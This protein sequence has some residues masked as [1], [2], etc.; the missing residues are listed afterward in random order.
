[1]TV[2]RLVKYLQM[3]VIQTE[4]EAGMDGA[5]GASAR[6]Q[7]PVGDEARV[8]YWV[9]TDPDLYALEQARIFSGPT[10]SYV[11]L[12][13]EV[14]DVGSFKRTAIGERP[15]VVVRGADGTIR[16][17]ENRCA[18][19][20]VK[21][22]QQDFGTTTEFL[23]PYH[24]WRYDL[25]G[26]LTSVPYRRGL[27]GQGGM[28][29]EFRLE[30]HSLKQLKVVERGGAV[31]ASFA[32]APPTF[33]DY[34]GPKML[35]Y[36]D[37]LF[38]GRPLEVLGYSRQRIPGNWKLMLENIKDPYHAGTLHVFFVTFGLFR[39]DQPSRIEM[40]DTGMHAVLV[41]QKGEQVANEV[42]SNL[43]Q[44][45]GDLRLADPRILDPVK[46]F[47]GPET[48]VMQTLWPNV[49]L[50]Q[51]TNSLSTRQIQPRGPGAFDFVW[52]HFTY[53]DDTPEMKQRRLRQA[54]LFGPAGLV[55]VDDGEVIEM[56]Q[57]GLVGY[58]EAAA[59]VEMGGYSVDDTQH[60]LTEA[61]IRKLYRHYRQVMG[62]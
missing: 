46:E 29:K 45:Q 30:D 10:W 34:L 52:T 14:P 8:P 47:A 42:T 36:F 44:F 11:A 27:K 62:I 38:N 59:V 37:R 51:Q 3:Q 41:S 28:P 25:A 15:V 23:C 16:V 13:S 48:V 55:S 9:Y 39:A 54:N 24:Q 49:I 26:A 22:C 18:H 57:Q 17:V 4:G 33:E 58:P 50:Q 60:Q 1:M 12:A 56:A 2:Y 5:V 32:E 31:F 40:D 53:A 21:F 19:R 6:W 61:A 43:G 7:W 20:G 35:G